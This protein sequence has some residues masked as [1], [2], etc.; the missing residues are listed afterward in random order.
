MSI[1]KIIRYWRISLVD[2]DLASL[3]L[4]ADNHVRVSFSELSEGNINSED[5]Q[6]LF[7]KST[8]KKA[9]SEDEL[10]WIPVISSPIVAIRPGHRRYQ[11]FVLP[12]LVPGRLHRNG[13]LEVDEEE[14]I[15][16]MP[17]VLLEPT[18]SS[19][20]LGNIDDMNTSQESALLMWEDSD[21]NWEHLFESARELLESVAGSNWKE[22]LD[23]ADYQIGNR[24]AIIPVNLLRGMSAHILKVYD[25]MPG[26]SSSKL[27]LLEAYCQLESEPAKDPLPIEDW[28]QPAALH[29]GSFSNRF[30]LSPSQRQALYHFLTLPIETVLAISG[31]PGTGKTTLLHSVIASLWVKAALEKE[32]PPVIVASSTNNQAVTNVIDSLSGFDDFKRWLP[33]DSFGLY[34]VNTPEKQSGANDRGILTL[35]RWGDG[36]PAEV[37]TKM[38]WGRAYQGFMSACSAHFEQEFATL[39]L[40]IARIHKELSSK[41][42][43]LGA[44]VNFAYRVHGLTMQVGDSIP[45][46]DS[47]E[48]FIANMEEQIN[49]MESEIESW[50]RKAAAWGEYLDNQPLSHRWFSFLPF[51]SR[52]I[53]RRRQIFLLEHLPDMDLAASDQ[54]IENSLKRQTVN[55]QREKNKLEQ[56]LEAAKELFTDLQLA[57]DQW[58]N[59]C[60]GEGAVNLEVDQ[61]FILE[62]ADGAVNETCL[63]NWLDKTL[64][65]DL[66][67]LATHYW[68]G[69]WFQEVPDEKLMDPHYKESQNGDTQR[70]KWRR[71]AM[72]TPC[73]VTTMYSGPTFFDYYDGEPHPLFDFIDLLI[74]DE[75][76][77]VTPEVS[78]GMFALAKQALAVGDIQQIEPV[79]SIT[80]Q[81]DRSNLKRAGLS[82]SQEAWDQMEAKG[83]LASSGSVMEMAQSV[84]PYQLHSNE[85][86]EYERGMFLAEH[87]RCVPEVIAYCNELAYYGRLRPMRR[88][89]ENYP[90]PH[91]GY[92]HVKGFSIKHGGSRRSYREA[93]AV[94]GWVVEN[95]EKLES[96]YSRDPENKVDIDDIVGIVTPFAAQRRV[97]QSLLV[98]EGLSLS[99]IG[100]VHTLQGGERPVILFSPVYGSRDSG[101]Y[102]FDRGPNMLNVAVSRASDSFLVFG[103]MDIFDP[104][105]PTPSGVLARYLFAQQ[106]NEIADFSLPPRLTDEKGKELHLVKTLSMHV[107]T[108]ARAFE[109]AEEQLVIVSPFL[110]WRA[111][112]ADNIAEKTAAAVIRGVDVTIYIDDGFN[113]FLEHPSAAR[114]AQVLREN[115]AEVKLC[116]NIHSKIVCVDREIFVEGSFNWLSAVRDGSKYKRHETSMI[117][118]GPQA[119]TFIEDTIKDIDAAVIE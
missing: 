42:Q 82:D 47:P 97:I 70:A 30:P 3:T 94:V 10:K 41:S 17:R 64:R 28:A 103:D 48:D 87:R 105:L 18:S 12:V 15:P 40:A 43:A 69:K 101:R 23:A 92:V 96:Y 71:Y 100:T 112:E 16:W 14:S 85:A 63:L 78:G 118:M 79:W 90:W 99:K 57:Q 72:L 2:A 11:K 74:V 24:A 29:L 110:R 9:D 93:L 19:L 106:D 22:T 109:R 20:V 114:A 13:K 26:A 91:I 8:V 51:I 52:K 62:N 34:L 73:F 31:P 65:Y 95:R 66:F 61:L 86:A 84:S 75:A 39:D 53:E 76:G 102:F 80:K 21:M 56:E 1:R 27:K 4:N 54:D 60:E 89:I 58:V 113:D 107:G 68:E 45:G 108:L 44:G 117:Y 116:H 104:A 33:I 6:A 36:F 59:W 46:H 50:R 115:G 88:S 5:T 83:L 37:E 25:A 38:F 67:V 98:K 119:S 7:E 111:I 49:R 77:Q 55:L 35:N 81:V 32:Q